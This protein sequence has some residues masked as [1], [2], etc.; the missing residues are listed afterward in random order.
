M[1]GTWRICKGNLWRRESL[2]IEAP[3]GN[4]EGDSYTGDLER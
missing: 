3:M 4:L 2:Y 1:R